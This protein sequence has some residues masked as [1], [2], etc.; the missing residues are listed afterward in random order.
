MLYYVYSKQTEEENMTT[1]RLD[2]NIFQKHNR[3]FAEY[4]PLEVMFVA[5]N[6]TEIMSLINKFEKELDR[7]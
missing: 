4:T 7:E 6:K 3:W 2:W 5:P 1:D